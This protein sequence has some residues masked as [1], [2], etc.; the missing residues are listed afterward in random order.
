MH[1]YSTDNRLRP[2]IIGFIGIAS[3]LAI[4]A[5]NFL[6]Q[7]FSTFAGLNFTFSAPSTGL[8][9]AAFYLFFTKILWK[10][11]L[12]Q[13]SG[14]VK[15]PELNGKWEGEINSTYTEDGENEAT[16]AD[17]E[18]T[19]NWRKVEVELRTESSKSRSKGATMLTDHAKPILNYQY[20]NEPD[21]DTVDSMNIHRGTAE[22][23]YRKENGEEILE[24]NYYTGPNRKNQGT[25]RFERK[26][27]QN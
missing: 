6:L 7:K 8:M 10:S 20:E 23:E 3:F 4:G 5:V 11:S 19:Q 17:L 25:L 15:V 26:D 24:G 9:F 2:K 1:V 12:V 16:E 13:K 14:V 27:T 22:L 21:A 18:I